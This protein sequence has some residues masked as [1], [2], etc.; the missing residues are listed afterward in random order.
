MPRRKNFHH[1]MLVRAFKLL[2]T[3]SP[4]LFL[5]VCACS[6]PLEGQ[7]FIVTSSAGNYKLGLVPIFI[8]DKSDYD[9]L[10]TGYAELVTQLQNAKQ[11]TANVA[12][13]SVA[14]LKATANAESYKA[15]VL[16][17]SR[18][19]AERALLK[20][21]GRDY[22]IE[23]TGNP[24]VEAKEVVQRY[25]NDL[26]STAGFAS[27]DM[28]ANAAG[29]PPNLYKR[30]K[31][32]LKSATSGI[33]PDANTIAVDLLRIAKEFYVQLENLQIDYTNKE[34]A[35]I[36]GRDAAEESEKRHSDAVALMNYADQNLD[37]RDTDKHRLLAEALLVTTPATKTDG[38]G[39]F[40]LDNSGGAKYLIAL[41]ERKVVSESEQYAWIIPLS[42]SGSFSGKGTVILSNDNMSSPD[43]LLN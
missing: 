25:I 13:D 36:K 20:F 43:V 10:K 6:R 15:K 19:K 33:S 30:L 11:E 23:F 5:S 3:I 17:V 18:N 21:T 35:F 32:H 27:D 37:L 38:D 1:H 28:L 29:A 7:V 12:R 24:E 42:D 41:G 14:P 2:R 26:K 8:L 22:L 9:K 40:K 31:A 39:N 16:Q 4:L 34:K